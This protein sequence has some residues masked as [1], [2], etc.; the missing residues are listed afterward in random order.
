MN[1]RLESKD[2]EW[3]RKYLPRLRNFIDH[4]VEDKEDSQDILQETLISAS[5]SLSLFSN[6]SSFFTW[7][8]GIANHEISDFYRKKKIKTILFC[9]QTILEMK[10]MVFLNEDGRVGQIN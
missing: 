3:I 5:E 2:E 8:C 9:S 7:L 4:H 1:K 6:K 10:Y